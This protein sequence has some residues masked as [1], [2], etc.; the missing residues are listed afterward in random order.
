M[1]KKL[2]DQFTTSVESDVEQIAVSSEFYQAVCR[3]GE[4]SPYAA[5]DI[6]T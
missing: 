4:P 1:L 5:I 2:I 6:V 3:N